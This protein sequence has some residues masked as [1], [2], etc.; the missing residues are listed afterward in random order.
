MV[1]LIQ[2]LL[3][4]LASSDSYS[5]NRGLS[6]PEVPMLMPRA[7]ATGEN[8]KEEV[9]LQTIELQEQTDAAMRAKEEANSLRQSAEEDAEKLR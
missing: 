3:S 9:K 8:L 7:G 1:S 4:S 2:R 6:Q 5:C